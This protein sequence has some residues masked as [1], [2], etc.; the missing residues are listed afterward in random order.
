MDFPVVGA[1]FGIVARNAFDGDRVA[2]LRKIA[3]KA[4]G[5]RIEEL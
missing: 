5:L 1:D 2:N 4:A 3:R